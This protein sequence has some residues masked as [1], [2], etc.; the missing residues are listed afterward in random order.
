LFGIEY[1]Y[2][3][4]IVIFRNFWPLTTWMPEL[5]YKISPAF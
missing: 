4:F 1:F 3:T 2:G 5:Y